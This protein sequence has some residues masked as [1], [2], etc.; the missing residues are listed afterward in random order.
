MRKI[1]FIILLLI[2]IPTSVLAA[3]GEDLIEVLGIRI[4]Q[5]ITLADVQKRL[6]QAQLVETGE[7]GEYKAA[8]CY[9][10]PKCQAQVEFW[11]DELG[12]PDHD[13]IGFTLSRTINTASVCL[14]LAIVDC[15]SLKMPKGVKLGMTLDEYKAAVGNDVKLEGSF[16]QKAFERRQPMTE[17]ER[18]TMLKSHP[19]LSPEYLYWDIVI[20]VRGFFRSGVLD[21]LEVSRTQTN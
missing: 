10:S 2:L 19:D 6:G 15:A 8:F 17:A 16:Y 4:A 18:T 21:I 5:D 20:F 1:R 12:G 7:A 9:Y 11:S 13:L 3:N 14:E